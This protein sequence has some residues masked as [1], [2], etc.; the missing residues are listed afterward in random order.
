[1]GIDVPLQSRLR[2]EALLARLHNASKGFRLAVEDNVPLQPIPGRRFPT[3]D[4]TAT[5]LASV[6]LSSGRR[7]HVNAQNVFQQ[8]L[9]R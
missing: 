5:P 1:M 4:F 2:M 9:I 7:S 6:E 8:G 3:L